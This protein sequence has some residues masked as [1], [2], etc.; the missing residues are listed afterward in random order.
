[1]PANT[2]ALVERAFQDKLYC[3]LRI[4]N[5]QTGCGQHE[6]GTKMSMTD[7]MLRFTAVGAEWVLWLLVGLSFLSIAL[8]IERALYF[9]ARSVDIDQLAAKLGAALRAGDLEQA[10]QVARGSRSIE[11]VVLAAGLNEVPRGLHAVS[12]TLQSA[13]ARERLKLEAYL[14]V[15]GTLGNNAPFIGLLGTVIGIIRA[16]TELAQAPAAKHAAS[17]AVMSSVFE[18][19]VATAVGLFVAIPAVVA[20]NVFQR[21][22]RSALLR[23][24]VLAHLLLSYMKNE[25]AVSVAR[26]PKVPQGA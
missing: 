25:P 20:F 11:S 18:A 3:Y 1:V 5:G 14:P 26:P 6:K 7:L 21:K 17:T 23:V 24:D 2:S 22:A 12:E 4:G 13:K 9:R 16:S 8:I 10:R 15:L 19:L